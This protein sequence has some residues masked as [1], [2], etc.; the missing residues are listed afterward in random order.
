MENTVDLLAWGES[1]HYPRLVL[2]REQPDILHAGRDAWHALMTSNNQER[3]ARVQ[4][5]K[6]HWLKL[7]REDKKDE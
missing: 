2:D 6:E 4:A 1:L 3:L 7:M 5:R